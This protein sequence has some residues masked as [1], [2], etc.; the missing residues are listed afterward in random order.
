MNKTVHRQ[1]LALLSMGQDVVNQPCQDGQ[2]KR[3]TP[4]HQLSQALAKLGWQ[5][6][7][8][9]PQTHPEQPKI[10]WSA[11]HCRIIHLAVN[12]EKPLSRDQFP[13]YLPEFVKAFQAFQAKEGTHYPLIHTQDWLS[14][15]VG[16]KLKESTTIQLIHT[17]WLTDKLQGSKIRSV[18]QNHGVSKNRITP[19]VDQVIIMSPDWCFSA[20]PS[21]RMSKSDAKAK[22][23]LGVNEQVLL[24][25]GKLNASKG[26]DTLITA[27]KLYRDRTPAETINSLRCVIVSPDANPQARQR[28]E[29]WIHQ[30]ELEQQVILIE[31]VPS[32]Q[33]WLYYTAADVCIIP[34]RYE[35]FGSGTIAALAYKI[36]IVASDVDG[37]RFTIVPG[38]MGLLVPPGDAA[39]FAEAIHRVLV[40]EVL[41]QRLKRQT[42][43]VTA[44]ALSW[45]RVAAHLSDIYRRRLAG[46]LSTIVPDV[47]NPC[48]LYVPSEGL[49]QSTVD[50]EEEL[51]QVS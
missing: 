15:Q 31:S 33:H 39:A 2:N 21:P 4:V 7:W 5:I 45:N 40:D 9:T 26:I 23:G 12:G 27:L 38:E 19:E 48:I 44:S 49:S 10:E 46:S 17:N 28:V 25:V 51:M 22:L 3:L 14:A 37:L 41:A 29:Q 11:P 50:V 32:D 47:Q 36:P 43:D 1:P 13:E 16:L 24:Y 20:Q 30:F 35:P 18:A 42:T 34:S 6:D 8:F